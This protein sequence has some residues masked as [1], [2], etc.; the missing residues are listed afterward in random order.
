MNSLL[1]KHAVT[2]ANNFDTNCSPISVSRYFDIEYEITQ[3]SMNAER[4][5]S[6]L[7]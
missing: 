4:H 2:A 3:F 6:M 5:S 7:L 1:P